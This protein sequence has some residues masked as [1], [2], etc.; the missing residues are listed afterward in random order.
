MPGLFG[1]SDPVQRTQPSGLGQVL[2]VVCRPARGRGLR[3]RKVPGGPYHRAQGRECFLGARRRGA[4][5]AWGRGR[6]APNQALHTRVG[7]R[8][9]KARFSSHPNPKLFPR[10]LGRVEGPG[11]R[12][13]PESAAG[14]SHLRCGAS[15][16]A[17]PYQLFGRLLLGFSKE[18]HDELNSSYPFR[19]SVP[20]AQAGHGQPPGRGWEEGNQTPREGRGGS[21]ASTHARGAGAELS[22]VGFYSVDDTIAHKGA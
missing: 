20:C 21:R 15:P 13:Q 9:A 8:A 12:G 17:G 16:V 22:W 5:S 10:P 18:S 4:S 11:N 7:R 14:C 2:R 1:G 19:L 6:G 3:R